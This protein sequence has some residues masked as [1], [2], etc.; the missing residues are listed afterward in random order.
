VWDLTTGETLHTLDRHDGFVCGL[1]FSPDGTRLAS[2]SQD[3]T[4]LI[5]DVTEKVVGKIPESAV[6]GIEEAFRLLASTDAAQAQRGMEYLYRRPTES[7]KLCSG[8]IT[9]PVAVPPEKIAKLI[10]EL[11]SEDFTDRQAAVKELEAI[12]GEAI[13][14]LGNV[15]VKSSN[16]ETRKL[17][18]EVIGH[19]EAATLKGEDLRLV[20]MVELLENM[21]TTDARDLLVAWAAGPKGHR[22]TKEAT[23][24][25]SRMKRVEK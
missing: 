11:D 25:L 15:L 9:V 24:A 21:G 7:I 22:L 20:R 19:Y 8:K 2:T 10:A 4:V 14:A 17:A 1:A 16:P 6:V 12:G 13:D 5:W 23:A 18:G 3:G